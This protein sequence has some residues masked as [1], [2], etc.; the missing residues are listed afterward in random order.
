MLD[1]IAG[2][3][4]TGKTCEMMNRIEIAVKENKDVL[5]VIPDQFSFEFD[6]N[7]YERL[8]A[9][10]FNKVNVQSFARVAK[11]IFIRHGGVKGRYADDVVKNVMM[12]RTIKRLA[13]EESLSYFGKQAGQLSFIDS[14]L[15]IVKELTVSGISPEQFAACSER[16]DES[17]RDKAG[18]ISLIFLEYRKM[19]SEAGYKDGE[20]DISEA[21]ARAAAHGYFKGKTIF[22]DEFKSFTADEYSMLD[23]MIAYAE[24]VTICLTT[25]NTG[26]TGY[27]VF[28]TTD[29]TLERLKRSAEDHGIKYSVRTLKEQ[30]RYNS[31]ELAFFSRNVLRN[32]RKKYDGDCENIRI[33][34]SADIYGEGDLVCSEIRRLVMEGSFR[35]K[36]IAVLCRDKETY[37]P[38]MESAFERYGIPFYSDESYTAAHKSLFVFIRTALKLAADKYSSSEDWLR[39]MKTGIPSLTD[40]EIS[41]VEDHCYR[42]N[43][44]GKMWN[45]PFLN[46]EETGAELV[47]QKVTSPVFRLR[48]ACADADGK[49]ICSA[50]L[51]F[52]D[53]TGA[54]ENICRIY[55]GC[56]ADDAAA[57]SAVRELKQLWELLCTLLET[58]SRALDGTKISLAE[59]SEL[60]SSASGKLKLSSPPQTLD[61][62]RFAAVHTARL[63][64]VKAVFVIG[65]NE[66]IFPFAAKP[67]GLLSDRDRIALENVGIKLSANIQDKLAEERF[68]AYSA[69]SSP[70]DR[71]YISYARSDIAGGS[72]YPSVAV[73]QAVSMF[74]SGIVLD[75]EKR[76]L[77][78]FCMTPEA[79]YYQYV[80]NYR[81]N[82]TDSA[83][84]FAALDRIPEFSSR[85]K[86]LRS[87]ESSAG[88]R[89]SPETGKRLFGR[90]IHLS[91]SRFEDYRKCPFVYYCKKGLKIYAP[92]KTEMDSPSKG[93]AVHYCLCGFMKSF[94]KDRFIK[95][96]RSEILSEVRKRLDEYY[97]SSEIGGDYG[98]SE[99][100]KAAFAR[101]AHTVTDILA[102]MA[103]EFRQNE[104]VP[105]GFEYTLG[106]NG[107]EEPLRLVTSGGV[108]VYFDGTIDRV[109]VFESGGVKYIR[110]IDYKSGVKEFRFTDLLYGVN[111]QMLLYLFALTEEDHAGA[112]KGYVPAG[113]L[114]M[115]AKDAA[116]SAGRNDGEEAV[117]K[118][119]NKTYKMSGVVLMNDD[120]IR[121]MEESGNAEF[122]PVKRT[123][124]GYSAFSKLVTEKQ[125]ENL[126]KFSYAML[127]ETA[128]HLRDGRIEASPLMSERGSLP[129]AYCDYYAICGEYPPSKVRTYAE[130]TD[131]TIEAIM[132]G[133]EEQNARMD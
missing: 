46:D 24:R 47:R 111:M 117:D 81:R 92:K 71:L 100:Y 97:R 74:G 91:A 38:V 43:V 69:V 102:R 3:A 5:A 112:Y 87:V 68:A 90:S 127:E 131:K 82:D 14:G 20:G 107:D 129:C 13:S 88:H 55:D 19:L 30:F 108:T 101:L 15:E 31:G 86:Y 56:P 105:A 84:L 115:P 11:D 40:E 85:M 80:R 93:T 17:I 79:A 99:R 67:S 37:S 98:K 104:F 61:C 119:L 32:V 125:F 60:F 59:L 16:S 23:A 4:G 45:E 114:Y 120:V 44:D 73:G 52:L 110:V 57:L 132:N 123:K 6:G 25:E 124:D 66:G 9:V 121:A 96:D 63:S 49:Q 62:V 48:E 50:I 78:S 2:G 34:S 53:E 72:L 26:E 133:E 103:E 41:A 64:N 83:S 70:S 35:Y 27:S 94:G 118:A 8:G 77:L 113:V 18:D 28:E 39:Y 76:G 95:M 1:I 58:L 10:L 116:P 75:A 29:R 130:D 128:E 21:A 7:L 36:D 65:A 89:L 33:F 42:W 106:R 122:I 12:F 126:R 54:V 109:D 22:I 51:D